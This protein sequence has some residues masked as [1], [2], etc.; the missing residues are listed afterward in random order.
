MFLQAGQDQVGACGRGVSRSPG[1]AGQR[2]GSRQE[3][4]LEDRDLGPLLH[5][6]RTGL[7]EACAHRVWGTGAAA[8]QIRGGT[9]REAGTHRHD[10]AE[11][12]EQPTPASGRA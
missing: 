9:G 5:A 1:G 7:L 11:D 6:Q 10:C 3:T 12:L 2:L 4:R 8:V